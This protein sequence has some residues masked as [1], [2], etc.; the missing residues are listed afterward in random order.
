MLEEGDTIGADLRLIESAN[1]KVNES[2]LTGESMQVEKSSDIIFS[3]PVGVADRVNMVYMS[4]P[5]TYGRGMGIV[6]GCGMETEIGKIASALDN[7]QE[8]LTPLQ[9][10]L[11]KLSKALRNNNTYNSSSCAYS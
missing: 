6:S 3:E 11:A 9:K 4:T 7:E 10:V 8:E 5:V 1:L 2:S